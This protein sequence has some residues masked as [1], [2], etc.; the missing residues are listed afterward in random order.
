[1][2]ESTR[3]R[4]ARVLVEIDHEGNDYHAQAYAGDPEGND[5]EP[6]TAARVLLEAADCLTRT[7]DIQYPELAKKLRRGEIR[8]NEG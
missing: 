7:A 1:M 5:L 6:E 4:A 8:S 3:K 2:A